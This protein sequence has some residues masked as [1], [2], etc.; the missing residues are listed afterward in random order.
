MDTEPSSTYV[1]P[2]RSRAWVSDKVKGLTEA[3]GPA[4]DGMSV[5]LGGFT[6]YRR[7]IAAVLTLIDRGLRDLTLIDYIGALEADLLI[8]AGC[9]SSVRSCYCG[10]EIFGLAPMHRLAVAEGRLEAVAETEATLAYGLRAA[11]AQTDFMP[12]RIFGGTDM[13]ALRPDLKLVVSPYST[14]RYVA[15]P[16]LRPDITVIHAVMADAAGNAVL[17]GELGLDADLAAAS[18][19]TVVT[20]ERIVDTAEVERHG[21]D[22]LG[23]FVDAV[24]EAPRGAWP[25]SCLPDYRQDLGIIGDYMDA[26]RAGRFDAFVAEMPRWRVP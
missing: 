1:P 23:G 12:A 26:C 3:L 4:S 25:T 8:G 9:V 11:R 15:V 16:A 21:A 6:L 20:A 14:S 13:L 18:G 5:A 7:P 24:V 19:Y 2:L 17:G 10:M 22:L